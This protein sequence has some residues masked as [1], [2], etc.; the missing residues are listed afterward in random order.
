MT[1]EGVGLY[2]EVVP[3]FAVFIIIVLQVCNCPP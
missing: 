1:E 2:L 3:S